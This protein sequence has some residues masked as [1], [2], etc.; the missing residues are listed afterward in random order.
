MLCCPGTRPWR[1]GLGRRILRRRSSLRRNRRPKR[2]IF[3]RQSW[4][5][6]L[7]YI[8]LDIIVIK[9]ARLASDGVGL[10][11]LLAGFGAYAGFSFPFVWTIVEGVRVAGGSVSGAFAA[12]G[13]V[14]VAGGGGAGGVQEAGVQAGREG[15]GFDPGNRKLPIVE[16]ERPGISAVA[17]ADLRRAGAA[18]CAR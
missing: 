10:F 7:I 16:L 5:H 2:S 1:L 18:V 12:L 8:L 15:A 13:A 9:R 3:C 11:P 14:Q 6:Y 17:P 4:H